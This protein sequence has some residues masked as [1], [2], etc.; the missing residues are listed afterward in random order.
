MGAGT[1]RRA[2]NALFCLVLLGLTLFA[3]GHVAVQA[4]TV[5]V[6]LRLAQEQSAHEELLAEQRHLQLDIGRLKEPRRLVEVARTK[7]GMTPQAAAIKTLRPV[8]A[9]P[10]T[11]VS[12]SAP[13]PVS[14]ERAAAPR[15]PAAASVRQVGPAKAV[16]P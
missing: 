4:K 14:V 2:G 10:G 9:R 3:L 11:P 7:L 16:Q 13:A 15:L 1:R 6:G 12:G 8:L 5:E